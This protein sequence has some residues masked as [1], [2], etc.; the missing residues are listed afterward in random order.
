MKHY[1]HDLKSSWTF[2]VCGSKWYFM[3]CCLLISK[4]SFFSLSR[5]GRGGGGRIFLHLL[6]LE[7]KKLNVLCEMHSGKI[8]SIFPTVN[9]VVLFS[10]D[11]SR[12]QSTANQSPVKPRS[13]CS[14]F[15]QRAGVGGRTFCHKGTG[16]H[17][18]AGPRDDLGSSGSE[19][20]A[21]PPRFHKFS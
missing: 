13:F 7:K 19:F 5:H 4:Y 1:G 21:L 20:V 15:L 12:F 17:R 6:E 16:F 10:Q 3:L 8:Q 11:W 2:C 18:C 9:N 14:S